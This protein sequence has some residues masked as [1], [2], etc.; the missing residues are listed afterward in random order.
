MMVDE[1]TLM[2]RGN[3]KSFYFL[4]VFSLP[5]FLSHHR[6]RLKFQ[7]ELEQTTTGL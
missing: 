1:L 3:D 7:M 2:V 4:D 6:R 5:A